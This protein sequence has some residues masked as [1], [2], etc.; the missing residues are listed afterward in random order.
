MSELVAR[1]TKLEMLFENNENVF[2]KK[3]FADFRVQQFKQ[4]MQQ[5][6]PTRRDELWKYTEITE[7]FIPEN[8]GIIQEISAIALNDISGIRFVFINGHFSENLSCIKTLPKEVIL[9]TTSQ[10]LDSYENRIKSYL[11]RDFDIKKFPFAKLN[12]AMMTPGMFLEIPAN[13]IIDTP[14]QLVFIH[15]KQ[16]N[17][18]TNPRNI[19]IAGKQSQV[20]I[21]ENHFAEQAHGYFT[22]VVSDIYAAENAH[23]NYYKIQD[24]DLT[25]THIAN[26]F[27]E[28][29][30][31]S[32]VKTFSFSKGS[33]LAREDL[34]VFQQASGSETYLHGLYSL[35]QDQQHVDHHVHVD[36]LATNGTSSMV[37]KGIL[38]K[39]S[40]AVFNGK[41]HV[42]PKTQ[43]IN[44]H[45]ENHNLLLSQ[46]A[47]INS[48]PE[49]EIYAEDVK[50]T[51][52]AT[53]GQLDNEALFY[54][55][56]RGIE[57][58]AAHKMLI[59]AFA[60]EVYN[61]IEDVTIRQYIQQRMHSYDE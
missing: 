50:C 61:K 42:H 21:I 46:D 39:K 25:A 18:M 24:D 55:L 47:V 58:M 9:C 30:Q 43:H 3:W 6:F 54:L 1:Q 11:L 5:G 53:I 7:N 13:L 36:H 17:F 23:I 33:R 60:E 16:N 49:L 35:N 48:K 8:S 40:Q 38:D 27:I 12:S 37:Y 22:N 51:H 34:S 14:I 20:S 56:S 26:I 15:T 41:V 4:F 19:I 57:K 28:Q 45:Q 31:D 52:G 44:A 2:A 32:C 10:A 59:H 29:Q